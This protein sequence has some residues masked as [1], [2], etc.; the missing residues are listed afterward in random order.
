MGDHV[1]QKK[2]D[3]VNSTKREVL[4]PWKS[5][6]PDIIDFKN[7]LKAQLIGHDLARIHVPHGCVCLQLGLI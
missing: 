1:E 4:Q 6:A 2:N 3:K 5:T 7:S